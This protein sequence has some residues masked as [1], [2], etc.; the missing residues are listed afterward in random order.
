MS[1]DWRGPNVRMGQQIVPLED[2]KEDPGAHSQLFVRAKVEVGYA[3]CLCQSHGLRLV[4]RCSSAGRYHL[5]GWPGEG[6]RHAA[7][8]RFSKLAPSLSGRSGYTTAAIRVS[9]EGTSIRFVSPLQRQ[10]DSAGHRS[11]SGVQ[12]EAS[13]RKAVSLVG[14]LHWFWEE[15]QLTAWHPRWRKRNW[16][17]AASRLR[18]QAAEGV[19]NG[20]PLQEVVYVVPPY[21][22]Q[23]AAR[24]GEDFQR[25]QSRLGRHGNEERR[26]LMIGEIKSVAPTQ[27]GVRLNLCHMRSP[28]FASAA[29]ADRVQVSYRSAFSAAGEAVSARKIGIFLVERSPRGYLTVVDMA[30]MLTSRTYIPCDSSNEVSMSN[31]LTEHNRAFKKPL[32]Y[33]QAEMVFP[34]FVL[35]DC[36]PA[37]YV[38]V[39]GIRG[40]EAYE[41][42]KRAKQ[43]IYRRKGVRLIEWNVG[44]AMPSVALHHRQAS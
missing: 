36:D 22:P 24:I 38:E 11:G 40:Q 21:R 37:E 13:T 25:F 35:V 31:A 18:Q 16:W 27:W 5:A 1:S 17:V 29:L 23:D 19:L 41:R 7:H 34:D 39:Y 6:E 26:G 28:L 9:A 30:A 3:E 20:R 10:L 43:L 12:S 4:I 32:R 8:C 42:R 14:L 2:L 33:D 44:E 15:A